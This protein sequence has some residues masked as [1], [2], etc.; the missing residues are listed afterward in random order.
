VSEVLDIPLHA[1]RSCSQHG[2]GV[3]ADVTLA[4]AREKAARFRAVVKGGI[5][6]LEGKHVDI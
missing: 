5:D 1:P 6:P 2:L 4:Q 3:C